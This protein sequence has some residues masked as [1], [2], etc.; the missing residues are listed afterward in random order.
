MIGNKPLRD[1]S[2]AKRKDQKRFKVKMEDGIF[3]PD[4]RLPTEAEWEYAC[5]A[6]IGETQF[7]NIDQNKI[8]SWTDYTIRIKNGKEQ[9]RGKIRVNAM[10]GKGDYAGI[11][12][13][14]LN[15]G[16]MITTPVYSY[17]PNAYGLYNMEGNV[18]EWVMDVYR[19]LS[20]E[21]MEAFMPFRG[22]KFQQVGGW[23]EMDRP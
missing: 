18:S 15:D 6:A 2:K 23:L 10:R 21:D 19:P 8:Y 7:E 1:Y 9:D 5:R 16:G 17:W 4:Y 14:P 11:A 12:G 20:L 13:G 3:L 22:N